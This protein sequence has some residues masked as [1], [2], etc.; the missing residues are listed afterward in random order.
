MTPPPGTVTQLKPA[1]AP[2]M[3]TPCVNL[4]ES[5]HGCPMDAMLRL[6]SGPWTAYI[7]WNL[8]Q[9]GATRFGELKRNVGD[10]SAKV[11][12]E[13]L[14]MLEESGVIS[15]TYTPTIPPKVV[16]ELTSSGEELMKIFEQ[17]HNL[18]VRWTKPLPR[19]KRTKKRSS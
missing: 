10:I 6:I 9:S 18:A 1:S 2:A 12:T 14:R 13:R 16:Y 5:P 4:P 15:R 3:T 8:H 7:M 11:L 19:S 17:L